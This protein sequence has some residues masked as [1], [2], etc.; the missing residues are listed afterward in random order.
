MLIKLKNDF[1]ALKMLALSSML[2]SF[3]GVFHEE[4]YSMFIS[5]P[6]KKK[7]QEL[8][9]S[10]LQKRGEMLDAG[11]GPKSIKIRYLEFF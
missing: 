10:L 2:Q 6:L 5:R 11:A 1:I 3:K 7:Q 9:K 4:N 8:K